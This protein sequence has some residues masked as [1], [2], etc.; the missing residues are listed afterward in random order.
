VDEVGRAAVLLELAVDLR[1]QREV[2]RIDRG[3]DPRADRAEGVEALGAAP[4]AV[5]L[6]E[7]AGADVVGDRVPEDDARG[8]GGGHVLHRLADD[9]RQLALEVDPADARR[10]ADGRVGPDDRGRRLDEQHRGA[11]HLVAELGRV[12]GVV[13]ADGDHLGR[14]DRREQPDVG[15]R[16]PLAGEVRLA[17]G[18]LGDFEDLGVVTVAF[19]RG[20]RDTTG[21]SNTG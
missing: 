1:P 16:P 7:V 11:G 12:L 15:Q 14:Q 21:M 6:L 9:D 19:D 3:L 20:E 4:L 13:A 5:G 18:V 10:A 8:A 2:G 17:E